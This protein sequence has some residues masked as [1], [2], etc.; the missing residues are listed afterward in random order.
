[1]TVTE[2]RLDGQGHLTQAELLRSR[3]A[4]LLES[5]ERVA[6]QLAK[7]RTT[8][9]FVADDIRLTLLLDR[10]PPQL[11]DGAEADVT[12]H[13]TRQQLA[14]VADGRFLTANA[15][16]HGDATW[17]GPVRKYLAVDAILRGALR[18][19]AAEDQA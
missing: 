7:A 8:V 19:L 18:R 10:R 12:L 5:D 17:T 4:R 3:L 14:E 6:R 15:L 2:Q 11:A 13:L 16:L 9:A 1:M